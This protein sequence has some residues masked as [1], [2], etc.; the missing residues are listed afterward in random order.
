MLTGKTAIITG[1]SRGIGRAIALELAEQGADIAL[2]Y[3]GNHG[4][5]AHTCQ[6]IAALGRKAKAYPCDVANFTQS[7]EIVTQIVA[8]LGSPQILVNNAGIIRD[9][10]ILTLKEEDF[11]AV[12]D[13]NLKGAFNLIKHTAPLMMRQKTGRILNLSSVA[14]LMGNA[15]Q[16]NYSAAKA[17]I[18]GLT[19]AVAREL[20]PRNITCNAIAPGFIETEMTAAMP[21]KAQ[22][23]LLGL[24]PLKRAGTPQDIAYLAAFLCS[25]RAGYITGEIIKADGGLYI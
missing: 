17:G 18:I 10:L 12:V 20:A 8:D 13:T 2:I 24:I 6:S 3:A 16:S 11:D 15:G 19:K 9:G 25:P 21:P 1:G 23:A 22:E 14:G 7:K 4:A 5:A